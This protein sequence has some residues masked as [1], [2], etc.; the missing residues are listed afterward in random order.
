MQY[1]AEIWGLES[2]SLVIEKIHL[3]AMKRFLGMDM[4]TPNDLV[5]GE[6]GR[7]P[8]HIN[9]SIC[10]IGYWFKLM[11]GRKQITI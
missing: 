4:R 9:S 2:T 6:L 11:C 3:F 8:V 7:Y 10:C 5:Y 1:G